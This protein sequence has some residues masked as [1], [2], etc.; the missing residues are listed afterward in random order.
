[1]L[2]KKMAADPAQSKILEKIT[3]QTFRASEIVNSL[4]SFSRTA[5][6][7]LREID[8]NE[9]IKTTLALVE[10]QM[11]AAHVRVVTEFDP[12]AAAIRGNASKLQQVFLNLFL[13]ARDAMR[14]GGRLTVRTSLAEA[15]NGEPLARVEVS[16]N[17]PG[18]D[19]DHLGRIFDPF[20]TTKGPKQGTGLGLAVTYG[21][22]QEHL[23][24][25]TVESS[26]G[27]GA[28]FHVD[29]PVARKPIHA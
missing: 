28:T 9:T 15:P 12:A 18:I 24:N 8:L 16:D 23:G 3:S 4:L 7:E 19:P 17:G 5:D 20:F 26:P 2:A 11:R 21:I 22:V 27:R 29:L 25:I 13:N 10:P 1:M 14:E 6:R